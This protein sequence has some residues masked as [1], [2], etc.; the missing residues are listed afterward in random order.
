MGERIVIESPAPPEAVLAAIREDS[1]EWRE[2]VIPR[3]LRKEL[4]FRVNTGVN[5]NQFWLQL[6]SSSDDAEHVTLRGVVSPA[7]GGGSVIRATFQSGSSD[8]YWLCGLGILVA[9]WS[10]P[11]GLGLIAAGVGFAGLDHLHDSRLSRE[12]SA[13]AAYLDERLRA[14]V[15]RAAEPGA[16]ALPN[17]SRAT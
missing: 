11:W 15:M 13:L 6:P 16:T 4:R 1:R 14:A 5:G 2:S 8:F 7:P 12:T 10:L 9:F 3:A 17:P